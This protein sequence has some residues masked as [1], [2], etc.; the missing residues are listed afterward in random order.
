IG[1]R[2]RWA[3]FPR[4]EP[5][6]L[7]VLGREAAVPVPGAATTGAF[8]VILG[9]ED[10]ARWV[11]HQAAV[12]TAALGAPSAR[13]EGTDAVRLWQS[14]ADLEDGEGAGLTFATAN[15]TPAALTPLLEGPEAASLVFHAPAGRL[16]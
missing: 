10:E 3:A 7:S 8:T 13:L 5:A 12:A 1:D 9:L 2:A 15:N 14:L 6:V 4:L 11:A 16:H